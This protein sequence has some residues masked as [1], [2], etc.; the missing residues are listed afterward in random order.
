MPKLHGILLSFFVLS[1]NLS[2]AQQQPTV[3]I[4]YYS[5]GGHTKTMAE[6]VAS[7]ARAGGN[8]TV[9]LMS[10]ETVKN[11]DL[12]NADA[13]IVGSPV[14]NANPAP[15]VAK[16]IAGWPFQGAPLFNKIGA[17]FVTAGGI[18]AGEELTQM[19]IL[20]SMMVFGMVVVG[21]EDWMS[22]FGASAVTAEKPFDQ[23]KN[24]AGVTDQFIKKAKGLGKRVAELAVRLDRNR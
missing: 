15:E 5:Q 10:V 12:M 9:K 20:H 17:A 1:L 3:L 16:F 7:G 8:V 22:A 18:S 4:A 21:G 2:H 13:I 6:A 23:A 11:E 19:S 14:Y 24:D